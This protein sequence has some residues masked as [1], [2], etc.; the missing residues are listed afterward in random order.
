MNKYAEFAKNQIEK[1]TDKEPTPE[2]VRDLALLIIVK[3]FEDE[4]GRKTKPYNDKKDKIDTMYQES[5]KNG[6]NVGDTLERIRKDLQGMYNNAVS[7]QDREVIKDFAN[8][9][10]KNFF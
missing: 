6:E 4:D 5:D 9:V 8:K 10:L 1:L 3:D 2:R 7:V